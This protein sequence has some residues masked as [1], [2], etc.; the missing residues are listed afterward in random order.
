MTENKEGN[1]T[2]QNR[3]PV[4]DQKALMAARESLARGANR[5]GLDVEDYVK[6]VDEG[7]LPSRKGLIGIL[8]FLHI[9][10]RKK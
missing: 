4:T 9:Y 5:M 10:R 1:G 6:A 7:T 3:D 2:I 8:Q